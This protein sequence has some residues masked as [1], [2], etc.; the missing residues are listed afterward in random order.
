MR[1]D[2]LFLSRYQSHSREDP[3]QNRKHTVGLPWSIRLASTEAKTPKVCP[4][5]SSGAVGSAGKMLSFCDYCLQARNSWPC[6]RACTLIASNSIWLVS[7][8]AE[9]PLPI[10]LTLLGTFWWRR[11]S[12]QAGGRCLVLVVVVF[13]LWL[14]CFVLYCVSR[15]CV[16]LMIVVFCVVL[17]W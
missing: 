15:R 3:D 11:W 16:L 10:Q 17:C 1:H 13:Y 5:E 8:A 9:K 12:S 6:L 14:L 2:N 7:S 4:F